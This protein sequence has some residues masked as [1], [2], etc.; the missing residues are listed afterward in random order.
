[1]E[2]GMADLIAEA[3]RI[4]VAAGLGVLLGLAFFGSLRWVVGRL[5]TARRP[6][7][8]ML[9]SAVVRIAVMLAALLVIGQ[10]RW[11][12]MVAVLAG[13]LVGR[14]IAIRTWGPER[15]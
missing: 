3:G 11:E 15:S 5:I 12:R 8:W 9:G 6:A 7:V 4:V 2:P 13:F 10:G 14:S 1:M